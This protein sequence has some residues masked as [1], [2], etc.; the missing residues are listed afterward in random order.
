M[1]SQGKELV[2]NE[3]IPL[4][5]QNVVYIF[6]DYGLLLSECTYIIQHYYTTGFASISSI[7]K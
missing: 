2:E 1:T 3:L 6:K 7:Y 5:Q 4:K